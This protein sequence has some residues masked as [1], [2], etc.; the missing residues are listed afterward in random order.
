MYDYRDYWIFYLV[1]FLSN[2]NTDVLLKLIEI[3]RKNEP[4]DILQKLSMI[5]AKNL[6]EYD[7][8]TELHS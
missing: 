8:L 2:G 7:A 6:L 3:V 5:K 4:N 1:Y